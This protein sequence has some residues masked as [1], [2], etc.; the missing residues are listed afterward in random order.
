MKRAYFAIALLAASWLPAIGYFHHPDLRMSGLLIAAAMVML[1]DTYHCNIHRSHGIAAMIFCVVAAVI[2]PFPYRIIPLLAACGLALQVFPIPVPWP[3]TIGSAAISAAAILLIQSITL[4]AYIQLIARWNDLPA[5]IAQAI[6]A[7]SRFIGI[8]A[9]YDGQ[10]IQLIAPH[11]N[12]PLAAT[13]D[14]L[15]D[16]MTACFFAGALLWIGF[17]RP[18]NFLLTVVCLILWLP[19]RIALMSGILSHR[20]LL[21][22]SLSTLGLMTQFWST[23][24][25]LIL[26]IVPATLAWLLIPAPVPTP[27][28]Q[29]SNRSAWF[30]VVLACAGGAAIAMCLFWDPVG[31]RE[32]GRVIV[33]EFHSS[34]QP[35]YA[36]ATDDLSHFYNVS[37]LDGP[38]TDTSL[39]ACDVFIVKSPIKQFETPEISALKKFVTR[40]GGL[41]LLGDKTPDSLNA[42]SATF[43]FTFQSGELINI[44][45]PLCNPSVGLV[46][47]PIL[48]NIPEITLAP[49]CSINPN[50]NFDRGPIISTGL[51]SANR[52]E[53]RTDPVI[54]LWTMRHLNGRVVGF[55]GAE[56]FSTSHLTEPGHSQL[57]T[58]M[59]EWLNHRTLQDDPR[60]PLAGIG[61]IALLAAFALTRGKTSAILLACS[62]GLLGWSVS[63]P[64]ISTIQ[65][66]AMP[67]PQAVQH[68]PS[69]APTNLQQTITSLPIK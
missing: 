14:L 24:V 12:L 36:P 54:Q 47:H 15:I 34:W 26:L 61:A 18:R 2:L 58:G 4:S 16:P 69:T 65:H 49:S 27:A 22:D 35:D 45:Q 5:C 51:R 40:G 10:S 66:R 53:I 59:V 37:K 52:P 11:L 29:Q 17:R 23:W 32:K 19:A 20:T 48:Q 1:L 31:Q 25:N 33:D 8:S 43:G 67:E 28:S 42:L 13:W 46:P 62:A 56:A 55:A 30:A 3:R 6:V 63:I 44:D 9:T 41:L 21:A 7:I 50:P 64:V 39:H 68:P 60:P 38:I 57:L